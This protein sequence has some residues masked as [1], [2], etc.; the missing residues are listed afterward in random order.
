MKK[1]LLIILVALVSLYACRP[2]DSD[3]IIITEESDEDRPMFTVKL[4]NG[5]VYEHFYAEEIAHSLITGKWEHDEDL[6]VTPASEYQVMLEEDG[7]IIYD[8]KRVVASVPYNKIGVLDSV[9]MKDNE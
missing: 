7:M 1:L 8:W 4:P 3:Q 5:T 2:D 9:F 6:R